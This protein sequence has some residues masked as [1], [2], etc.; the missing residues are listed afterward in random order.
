[1]SGLPPAVADEAGPGT[2]MMTLESFVQSAE[3]ELAARAA[4]MVAE[5]PGAL[6]NPLIL[7]GPPGVGKTHLL[8]AIAHRTRA[9]DREITVLRMSGD[10][11][12]EGVTRAAGAGTLDELHDALSGAGL[13]L[14]D[15]VESLYG[16]DLTQE[17]LAGILRSLRE[18]SR[19]IVITSRVPVADTPALLPALRDALESSI[20]IDVE[21][22]GRTGRLMLIE[23]L[24]K[25]QGVEIGS[26]VLR[27]L[28]EV[29]AGDI[30]DLQSIV[31]ALAGHAEPTMGD[32]YRLLGTAEV[33]PAEDEFQSFLADVAQTVSVVV[34]TSPWRRRIVQAILRWEGEGIET[35]R[36]DQALRADTPPDLDL[37]ID[38]F[39][40]DAERLLQIRAALDGDPRAASLVDPDALE[41]AET[42]LAALSGPAAT[43]PAEGEAAPLEGEDGDTLRDDLD[44]APPRYPWFLDPVRVDLRWTGVEGR[45]AEGLR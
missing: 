17:I 22:L 43:N 31:Q 30:R 13:F 35:R 3:N 26:D 1:M 2:Q 10:D 27:L 7:Q 9:R 45:M 38:S 21:P 11:F 18:R 28:A 14:L 20:T 12:A 15:G 34:E 6:Y 39:S 16:M 24:V 4:A 23:R 37:L 8:N 42:L 19:Q 40:R 41:E 32:V 36:L 33:A 5:A 29:P 25:A 44:E